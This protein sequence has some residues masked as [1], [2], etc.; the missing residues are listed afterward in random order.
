M[1]MQSAGPAAEH[2]IK[3]RSNSIR[4]TGLYA[5]TRATGGEDRG[6]R[7]AWPSGH[8]QKQPQSQTKRSNAR[9]FGLGG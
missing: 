4:S 9:V 5:V 6:R 1:T 3:V 8:N 7:E 2:P